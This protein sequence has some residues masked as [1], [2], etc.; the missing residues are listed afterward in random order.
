MSVSELPEKIW[1]NMPDT[2]KNGNKE[3]IKVLMHNLSPS[4]AP[5]NAVFASNINTS[6]VQTARIFVNI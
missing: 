3:G 6:K 5:E 1:Q 2:T 4:C